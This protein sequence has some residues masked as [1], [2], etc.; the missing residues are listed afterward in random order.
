MGSLLLVVIFLVFISLGLPDS[1]LGSGWPTMQVEFNVPS[2][3]AGYVS[4]V[5]SFM[6]IVSALVS[7]KIIS[8]LHTK[9]IVIISI[10][11]TI[12]GLLGFSF[13][14]EYWM[15]FIFAIPYGLGAGAIDA[16]INHYVAN[17]Y[18]G[19][20]MNFLHCFYGI[21]AVISPNIM[22][23]ALKYARWNEGYRWTSFIQIG[24]LA[25]VILSLLLWKKK[26]N[27]DNKEKKNDE[28]VGILKTLKVK[29]V[30]ATLIAFFAYCSG[31]A[32]CFLR[33]SSYFAGTKEGLSSEVIA[34]CG[35]LIFGGLML[36][37]L[38]S[39]FITNKIGDKNMIRIGISVEFIG[40]LLISLSFSNY[41]VAIIGFIL[42]GIGMGPIY[43]S[44]MHMAPYKFDKK[45]SAS[46][47]GLQ[48][49]FA[50]IGTTFMPMLFGV[51]QQ[52]VGM[53]VM[54]I[55]LFIFLILNIVLIEISNIRAIKNNL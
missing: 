25:V 47:I 12:V 51:I 49:A 53:W 30:I 13:C 50:Y 39:G 14:K 16:S 48:M 20:I 11:L 22:S 10:F 8:K 9:W 38:I 4:M 1:L 29:G 2:S 37:R 34:S 28:T 27:E 44:I 36:G 31:E 26:K 52:Y 24:I 17:N 6:T 15:L 7:P 55:F 41:I 3:Y 18:S 5:I 32:I 23:L 43:P 40:I 45:Y 54:P 19:S 33:T 35:S 46:I 21:G 42:T